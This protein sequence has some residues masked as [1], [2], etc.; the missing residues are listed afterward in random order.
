V[1]EAVNPVTVH[2]EVGVAAKQ[3][4]EAEAPVPV[5]TQVVPVGLEG[6]VQVN[7]ALVWVWEATEMLGTSRAPAL[8]SAYVPEPA[9]ER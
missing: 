5:I 6:G 4:P 1:V 3:V 2:G 8:A 9:A 7:V